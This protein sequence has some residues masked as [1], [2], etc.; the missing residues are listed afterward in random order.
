MSK[1]LVDFSTII[2]NKVDSTMISVGSLKL[3]EVEIS[4]SIGPQLSLR[5][6]VSDT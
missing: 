1:R 2:F 3:G 4:Y 5:D 6:K